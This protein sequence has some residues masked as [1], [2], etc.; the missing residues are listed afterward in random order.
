MPNALILSRELRSLAAPAGA[1][2]TDGSS[3]RSAWRCALAFPYLI[4]R[5]QKPG[6]LTIRETARFGESLFGLVA[7]TQILLTIWL[8]PACVAG[9]IAES[10]SGED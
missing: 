10:A 9:A 2:T 5:I 8:V 1:R 7:L 6:L 3:S 4:L